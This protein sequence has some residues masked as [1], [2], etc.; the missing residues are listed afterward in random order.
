[1]QELGLLESLLQLPHQRLTT[2]GGKFGD[3]SFQAA[4]FSRVPGPCKF[5]AL[6]PQW[7]FLNFL[8]VRAKNF[9]A[10]DLRMQHAVVQFAG[11]A[12]QPV[13][14]LFQVNAFVPSGLGSGAVPIQ[15]KFG[16]ASSQSGVTVFV[17]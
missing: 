9:P 4:N 12:P 16:A 13:A 8:S 2:I 15:V 7:D 17:K 10:F 14:G 11:P 5:I 6:M 3:F 1:M